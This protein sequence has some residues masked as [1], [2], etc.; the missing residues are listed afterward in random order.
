MLNIDPVTPS[1]GA[2]I[3]GLDFSSPLA[4]PVY[5]EIYAALLQHLVVF[6]RGAEIDP[7]AHLAFARNFG[8]LDEPH[9]LYPHVAGFD[10][11]VLLENNADRP[12]DTNSWHTDLT[13]K[14]VQPFASVLIAREV[15]KVGGDT[16]WSSCY[17]AYDRLLRSLQMT[18]ARDRRT[19]RPPFRAPWTC[20]TTRR[21]S[22]PW[23]PLPATLAVFI[24]WYPLTGL[25]STCSTSLTCLPFPPKP[26]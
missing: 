8:E 24:P 7:G 6:I 22:P 25:S 13:F 18:A 14:A 23:M 5:D 21:S 12:P 2:E 10:N 3:S 16:M 11:I 9:L 20:V 4:E 15:P 17:A 26:I 19:L 1:I